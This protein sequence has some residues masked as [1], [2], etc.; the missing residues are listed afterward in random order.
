MSFRL[1]PKS[2]TL[3]DLERRNGRYFALGYFSEF[4]YLP[5][6]MRK[7]SR[8]LSSLLVSSCYVCDECDGCNIMAVIGPTNTMSDSRESIWQFSHGIE[9]FYRRLRRQR[10]LQSPDCCRRCSWCGCRRRSSVYTLYTPRLSANSIWNNCARKCDR[11]H[12]ILPHTV[13]SEVGL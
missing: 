4:A 10:H 12:I 11:S 2:V 7:S 13:T 3:N 9:R 8:S 1:V 6:V 5:S